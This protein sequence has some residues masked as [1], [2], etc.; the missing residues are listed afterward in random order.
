MA[1]R[2]RCCSPPEHFPTSRSA[3]SVMPRPLEHFVHRTGVREEGGGQPNG[4]AHGKVL[5]QSA[6]LHDGGDEAAGDSGTR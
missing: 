2:R 4:L 6:G 1:K 3:I 5:E